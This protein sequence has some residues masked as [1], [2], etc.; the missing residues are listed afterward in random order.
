MISGTTKIAAVAISI[1]LIVA[2]SDSGDEPTEPQRHW[3]DSSY[4]QKIDD[5]EMAY[6]YCPVYDRTF[7]TFKTHLMEIESLAPANIGKWSFVAV[8]NQMNSRH[9][10]DH[11]LWDVT[12]V[13]ASVGH[14]YAGLLESSDMDSYS[15]WGFLERSRFC[16]IDLLA[17]I[18]IDR[19]SLDLSVTTEVTRDISRAEANGRD[20]HHPHFTCDDIEWHF[21]A[22]GDDVN[23]A[24]TCKIVPDKASFDQEKKLSQTGAMERSDLNLRKSESQAIEMSSDARSNRDAVSNSTKTRI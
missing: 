4:V 19:S 15:G 14:Y 10:T 11:D 5:T 20:Q 23:A 9:L 22:I 8:T 16:G 21:R 12:P 1:S 2:C 24:A 13:S 6:L 18:S 7:D 3:E 17:R